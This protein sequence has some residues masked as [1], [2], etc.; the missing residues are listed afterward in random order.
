MTYGRF[1]YLYDRLM[2]D[3]PYEKWVKL[4]ADAK[5]KYNISG[6]HLLDLACGTGELSI[7][8][9][10]RGFQVTGV[11]IS[12]DMLSVAQDKTNKKGQSIFYIEQDMS[13]LEGLPLFDI[14]GVFCDSLNYLQTEE[15]VIETFKG[16]HR[17][18]DE[19]G[20][21]IFDVHSLYKMNELFIDQTYAVNDE[22]LSLIWQCYPGEYENSVEHDLTFFE[23]DEE[24]EMYNR[25]DELHCQRTYS[26]DQYKK[27]L[28]KT[29]FCLVDIIVDFDEKESK[30]NGERIFFLCQKA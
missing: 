18:L 10:E 16:V 4:I 8:L 2:S 28:K 3:V 11:D 22:E 17:H 9:A 26:I 25:Y 5:E 1:A 21:F 12:E 23:L 29:D 15:E 24:S 19:K 30:E 14:I 27:W 13:K 6:N 20:L 7:S